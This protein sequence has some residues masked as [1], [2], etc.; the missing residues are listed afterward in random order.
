M[1]TLWQRLNKSNKEK[2][3]KSLYKYRA[4]KLIC[5]LKTETSW[6]NLKFNSIIFLMQETSEKPTTVKHVQ[7]LFDNDN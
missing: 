2:L 1:K 4:T 5:E 6:S 7:K 3:K